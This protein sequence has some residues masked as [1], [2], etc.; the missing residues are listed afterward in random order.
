LFSSA[1]PSRERLARQRRR[2]LAAAATFVASLIVWKHGA[3]LS[4][5]FQLQ[6]AALVLAAALFLRTGAGAQIA[7]RALLLG[8]L[9]DGVHELTEGGPALWPIAAGLGLLAVADI[10]L[11][12]HPRDAFKPA[13]Y[14]GLVALAIIVAFA[15]AQQLALFGWVY[16]HWD[17][18]N[19]AARAWAGAVLWGEAALLVAASFGLYRLRAWGLWALASGGALLAWLMFSNTLCLMPYSWTLAYELGVLGITLVAVSA[20]IVWATAGRPPPRLVAWLGWGLPRWG[21][22]AMVAW[23]VTAEI[24]PNAAFFVYRAVHPVNF[25]TFGGG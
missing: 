19:A 3:D 11:G 14:R 7:A 12:E 6:S 10:G 25:F 8:G 22:V 9:L 4:F 18:P 1:L 16:R 13:A 24:A 2:A 5:L 23:A 17:G 20:P 15:T 21:V